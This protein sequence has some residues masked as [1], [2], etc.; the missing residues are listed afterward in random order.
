MPRAGGLSLTALQ[1]VEPFQLGGLG[2]LVPMGYS[3]FGRTTEHYCGIQ[4][5]LDSWGNER[6]S[7]NSNCL[8]TVH[9]GVEQCVK[10]NPLSLPRSTPVGS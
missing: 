7:I 2:E 4:S 3:R 6:W 1:D 10:G 8:S 9:C 5:A